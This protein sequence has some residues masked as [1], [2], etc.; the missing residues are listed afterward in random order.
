MECTSEVFYSWIRT[1]DDTEGASTTVAPTRAG[2]QAASTGTAASPEAASPPPVAPSKALAVKFMVVARKGANEE[3]AKAGLQTEL[4]R[5][6]NRAAERCKRAHESTG[7][8]LTTKLSAKSSTLNSLSF[9][10]RSQAEK[11]LVEE[12]QMQQGR[13]LAVD[14]SA[15]TCRD[16]VGPAVDVPAKL[17][18]GG[19]AKADPGKGKAGKEEKPKAAAAPKKK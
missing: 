12:C 5:Q 4:Q 1:L 10:A 2:A 9:S 6:K 14:A 7:D 8:C 13:C 3:S 16:V 15:P 18:D 11:A 17:A 19:G